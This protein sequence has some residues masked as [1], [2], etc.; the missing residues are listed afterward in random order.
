MINI[1]EKY[2]GESQRDHLNTHCP[3]QPKLK[4]ESAKALVHR[5]IYFKN[6]IKY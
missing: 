3:S 6:K 2:E 1:K 5:E 4:V